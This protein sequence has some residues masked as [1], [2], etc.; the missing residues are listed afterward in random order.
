MSSTAPLRPNHDNHLAEIYVHSLRPRWGRSILVWERGDKRGYQ[1]E[2]GRLRVFKRGFFHHLKV[3]D[4]REGGSAGL[5]KSLKTRAK[6][7]ARHNARKAEQDPSARASAPSLERLVETFVTFYPKGFQDPAWA[8]RQ[9]GEGISSR[10]LKRHR[11]PAINAAQKAFTSSKLQRSLQQGQARETV[12]LMIQHLGR[13]DLSKA[14]KAKA[15]RT[16]DGDAC[17]AVVKALDALLYEH[18]DDPLVGFGHWSSAMKGHGWRLVT[19]LPALIQP[20]RHVC[21][22]PRVFRLLATSMGSDA[23]LTKQPTAH[24]YRDMLWL[25]VAT[26]EGLEERGL[27][28][29]DLLDV[30]DFIW[31]VLRPS[32]ATRL[33]K[34]K[35]KTSPTL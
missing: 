5:V 31:T 4:R 27:K 32:A 26:R 29:R 20:Q 17:M 8:T 2:D 35:G 3:L 7:L 18:A 34:V 33:E 13:C 14:S 16:M 6:A 28:A 19:A 9:R 22:R 1:F 21:V 12:E 24:S 15:L 11:Q 10:R 23:L 30:H 25:A